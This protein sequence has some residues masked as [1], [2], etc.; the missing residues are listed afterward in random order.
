M[1]SRCFNPKDRSYARYGGRG[2]TVC[3]RWMSFDSFLADM[4][5]PPPG[6]TLDRLDNDGPYEPGNCRWATKVQQQNNMRSNRVV[7]FEGRRMSIAEWSRETGLATHVIRKRL[8][9]G[10]SVAT[11]LLTAKSQEHSHGRTA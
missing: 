6:M 1:K 3:T 8:N 5:H 10:W 2:I 4:G 9:R 11:A 7:E